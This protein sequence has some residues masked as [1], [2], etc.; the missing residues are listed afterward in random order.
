[1]INSIDN[2]LGY[3][4]E[5]SENRI[6]HPQ[7][8]YRRALEY[9]VRYIAIC[10]PEE[11]KAIALEKAIQDMLSVLSYENMKYVIEDAMT[12]FDEYM[13]ETVPKKS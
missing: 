1:M 3:L 7:D 11:V 12:D 13:D 6:V 10:L 2:F 8:A 5:K 4:A 9:A